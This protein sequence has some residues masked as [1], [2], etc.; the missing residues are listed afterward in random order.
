[1]GAALTG[2]GWRASFRGRQEVP[3]GIE[4]NPCMWEGFDGDREHGGPAQGMTIMLL[5]ESAPFGAEG[6]GVRR[7]NGSR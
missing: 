4:I 6:F 3:P 7:Q 1:L 2:S 5:A